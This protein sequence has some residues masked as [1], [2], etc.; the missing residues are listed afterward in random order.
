[1]VSFGKSFVTEHNNIISPQINEDISRYLCRKGKLVLNVVIKNE[2][3]P[4]TLRGLAFGGIF[5]RKF[6]A[7][8]K[9]QIYEKMS[10][11]NV[12]PLTP[13]PCICS[14]D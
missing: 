8:D 4:L 6:R 11:G 14:Q 9:A 13:N 3:C 1:M 7:S 2:E 10:N 5:G 12:R